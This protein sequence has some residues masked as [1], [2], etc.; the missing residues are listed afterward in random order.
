MTGFYNKLALS[1]I[2]M[3]IT[4]ASAALA[5]VPKGYYNA[6]DGKAEAELKNAACNVIYNHT[7]ISSYN[8]LPKYFQRTDVYPDSRRWWDMYSDKILYAPSFSGLN[9]EHSFPKSWWGGS[10]SV[11][12]YIDLNHL[13]PAEMDANMAK[14]NYPLGEVNTTRK[15]FDNGVSLVGEAV[16][17]QGGGARYVFEPADEYKGDF[18]RTYFYMVTCYQSFTWKYTY[19]VG[20]NTYPTLNTWSQE[21]LLKWHREDPVSQ[22]EKDRNEVI[23]QIQANRNPFIDFPEL[24]EYIWGNRRGDVFRLSEH[25]GTPD[26]GKEPN[27]IT[28]VQ[29][30]ELDFGQV[31]LGSKTI[32]RLH[33]KGENLTKELRLAIYDPVT[34]NQDTRFSIDGKAVGKV[35]YTS[36][37]SSEGVWVT[38]TYE[39][40][41]IGSDNAQLAISSSDLSGTGL[42][43]NLS[44]E[45]LEKPVLK[46]PVALPATDITSDSYVANW[47]ATDED[48]DYYVVNRTM[49]VDGSASTEQIVAEDT[50]VEI[51][52]YCGSES[53]TVQ[54][55]R[56]DEYSPESN[57]IF[58]GVNGIYGVGDDTVAPLAATS[59]DGGVTIRCAGIHDNVRVFDMAGR[60]VM[61]LDSVSDGD[62]IELPSGVYLIVTERSDVPLKVVVR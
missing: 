6:L 20:Q 14:S 39:P 25:G 46:A 32:S 19:M 62:V 43:I 3:L 30:M 58:V 59:V 34:F 48:V 7:E 28:P 29:G 5:D 31:A 56:L 26:S 38:I 4:V 37:N 55:V 50:Y 15:T 17:G 40:D 22:K 18:A 57:V 36:A 2:S 33:F 54:A 27:L 13:Y 12:A 52:D 8:D 23:Y 16:S 24:A 35:S 44:G 61:W 42:F 9:R 49:Y 41:K 51:T 47:E 45:C 10:T 60:I 53:Y 1:C 21:L 11:P